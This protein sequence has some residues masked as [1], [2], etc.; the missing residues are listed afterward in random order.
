MDVQVEGEGN[1]KIDL[2]YSQIGLAMIVSGDP[3]NMTYEYSADS[4][5]VSLASIEVDGEKMPEDVASAFVT[6]RNISGESTMVVSD[7]RSAKS[8]MKVGSLNFEAKANNPD[9]DES[10]AISGHSENLASTGNAMMPLM[11]DSTDIRV[12]LD[13]GTSVSG[14]FTFGAGG[15]NLKGNGDGSDFSAQG[16]SNG[17]MFKLALD[18]SNLLYE[19]SVN[20]VTMAITSS[21]LPFPVS[22]DFAQYGFRM[23]MPTAKAMDTQDFSLAL[24]LRDFKMADVLWSIFD[25]AGTLP[26]DP[27]TVVVDISGKARVLLDIFDPEAEE[28][29]VA[30]GKP[31]AELHA[32]TLNELLVSVAGADLSGT[33]DFTFD[34][35]DLVTYD[36]MPV[37]AGTIALK[38]V[39]IN[40]LI[41]KLVSM[42]LIGDSEVMGARMGMGMLTVPGDGEDTLI[43]NIEMTADG[44]IIANGQRIK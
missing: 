5:T 32:L 16:S 25:P 2:D 1:A 9:G 44:Q 19:F 34:N 20:G 36:G 27:A 37:P 31:P 17:G 28:A 4:V 24:M 12:L 18:S 26:R 23:N 21:D 3:G 7:M 43:S 15:Y 38:L 42:G 29:M 6:L 39:G 14:D 13:A 33:G 22:F 40:G 11:M 41:D 8:S 35:N 30:L 10:F